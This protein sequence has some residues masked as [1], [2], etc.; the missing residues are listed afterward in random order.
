MIPVL[1]FCLNKYH[2]SC[3][4][5]LFFYCFIK[6]IVKYNVKLKKNEIEMIVLKNQ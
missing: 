5:P 6:L 3:E 4:S 2:T 1:R